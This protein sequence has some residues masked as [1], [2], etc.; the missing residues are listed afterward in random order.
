MDAAVKAVISEGFS[1]RRASLQFSVPKS[2]LGDRVSGRV[3]PGSTSGPPRYL[4]SA[5]ENELVQ[6]LVRSSMIGYGKSRMQ[7]MALV[8]QVFNSKG[9]AKIVSSGWWESFCRRHPNLSLRTAAPS[10]S[11]YMISCK[12]CG[13][14]YVGQ[15]LRRR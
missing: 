13:I 15:T 5:E 6:F 1:I 2:S 11:L 7:V 9:I 8:Q 12:R 4:T 10:S 3:I 14:Q